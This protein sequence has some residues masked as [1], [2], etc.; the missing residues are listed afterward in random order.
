MGR[1]TQSNGGNFETAPQGNHVARCI[2]MIDLGTQVS[3]YQGKTTRRNQVILTW[4]LPDELMS[5]GK[6]FI[7]SKFYTNSL[8]E[9]ANL[10]ADLI[11]WRGRDFTA[12]EL[13]KFDLQSVLGAP[14]L[15]NVVHGDTGKAKVTT[16]AKLPKGMNIPAAVNPTLA[17]WLDDFKPE[18]FE[19]L[20]KGLQE[21]IS[22]S[23]EYQA[24]VGKMQ[25]AGVD[26][27]DIPF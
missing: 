2:R 13:Q 23:P 11:G 5:D 18:V 4:E 9:K 7:V 12:E 27:E 16:V 25:P 19:S 17:F 14:C 8:N 15:V 3:E 22:K 20:G 10:R 6:P 24:A 1:F 21:M 26:D